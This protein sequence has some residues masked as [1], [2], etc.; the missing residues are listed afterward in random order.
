VGHAAV[1]ALERRGQPLDVDRG[2]E[3]GRI[4]LVARGSEQEVRAGLG[5][6]RG[7]ALLVARVSGEVAGI[8]ELRGVDEQRDDDHVARRA[9]VA[10]KAQMSRVQRAH[11]RHEAYG[12]L[13]EARRAE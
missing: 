10:D 9:R 7:V 4:D 13:G 2:G 8:V 11:R 12:A 3:A 6:E 5:G 1:C